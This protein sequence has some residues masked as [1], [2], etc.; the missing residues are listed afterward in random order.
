MQTVESLHREAME[1]ID[2]AIL[3]R[4]CGDLDRAI[5]LTKAAFDKERAA[6]IDRTSFTNNRN[7]LLENLHCFR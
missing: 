4:Q 5:A 6:A 3:A 1:S 2:R 7:S